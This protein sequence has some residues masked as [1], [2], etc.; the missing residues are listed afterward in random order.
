MPDTFDPE[1]SWLTTWGEN[2]HPPVLFYGT[3]SNLLHKIEEHGLTPGMEEEDNLMA[4]ARHILSSAK[5]LGDKRTAEQAEIILL[6]HGEKPGPL[7]LTFNYYHALHLARK[8]TRRLEA[9]QWL[10]ETFGERAGQCEDTSLAELAINRVRYSC[11]GTC[12]LHL[13]PPGIVVYVRTDLSKFQNLSPLLE[14]KKELKRALKG[15]SRLCKNHWPKASWWKK[16]T[17]S[18]VERYLEESIRGDQDRPGL[19]EEVIT[20]S[21]IP[22]ADIL[23]IELPPSAQ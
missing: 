15:K 23:R 17:R 8:K 4:I 21:P 14:D 20:L 19:G 10:C 16:L 11:Q 6:E 2:P 12:D 3:S 7:K 1:Y 5:K 13:N 18:A 22:I 9:L